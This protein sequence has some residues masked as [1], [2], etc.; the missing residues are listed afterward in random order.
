[1]CYLALLALLVAH[2]S[3][4]GFRGSVARPAK[5]SLLELVDANAKQAKQA[6]QVQ[7]QVS[8]AE[9]AFVETL[10]VKYNCRAVSGDLATSI[11]SIVALNSGELGRLLLKCDTDKTKFAK[12]LSQAQREYELKLP[13]LIRTAKTL[14][15]NAMAAAVLA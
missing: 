1:M 6:V 11:T 3:A 2:A 12:S 7:V 9:T 15:D 5:V 10:A 8:D 13:A 14:K 4:A